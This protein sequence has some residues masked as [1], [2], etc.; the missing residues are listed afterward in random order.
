MK[1]LSTLLLV[2]VVFL[3]ACSSTPTT[4]APAG[5][6]AGAP[7]IEISDAYVNAVLVEGSD[8]NGAAY[9]LIKNTGSAA[10]RLTKVESDAAGMVQ[11]HQSQMKD[12]VMSMGQ[13]DGLDIP[14]NG[15]VE[16]KSGSYH[17]MLM[18]LKPE[19]KAGDVAQI[20]L[21]FEKSGVI[22]VQA[23]VRTP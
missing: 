19:L 6:S 8:N 18:G 21:T 5:D 11:L 2:F 14:A 15:Q 17:V 10:D 12:G 1:H 13:I 23:P 9:M 7:K 4:Q 20:T 22:Q 16:L 3:A